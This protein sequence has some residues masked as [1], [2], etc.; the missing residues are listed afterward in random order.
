MTT[1]FLNEEVSLL[2]PSNVK[3]Y[4]TIFELYPVHGNFAGVCLSSATQRVMCFVV[5]KITVVF[6]VSTGF[7][8]LWLTLKKWYL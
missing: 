1:S 7:H 8:T 4:N 3:R 5:P 2:L 6:I